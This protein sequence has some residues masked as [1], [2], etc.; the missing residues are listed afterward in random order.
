MDY[1]AA[2]DLDCYLDTDAK[3]CAECQHGYYLIDNNCYACTDVDNCAAHDL[4]CYLD[5]GEKR[6]TECQ[7]GYYLTGYKTCRTECR[8]GY[9]LFFYQCKSCSKDCSTDESQ[10]H[11]NSADFDDDAILC[12]DCPACRKLC[13]PCG[14]GWYSYGTVDCPYGG[15]YSGCDLCVC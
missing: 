15:T 12:R 7:R 5:T 6:C 4:D 14:A 2:H 11:C 13:A 9:F 1:C 3:T 8:P 10:N